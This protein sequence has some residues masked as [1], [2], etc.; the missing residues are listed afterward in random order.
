MVHG[1]SREEAQPVIE[2]LGR[3]AGLPVQALFSTRRYKQCGARYFAEGP[4]RGETATGLI[5][6]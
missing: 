2:R 4:S 6:A 3:L 1:R 5:N